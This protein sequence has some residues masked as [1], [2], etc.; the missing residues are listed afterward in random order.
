MAMLK[1]CLF[2]LGNVLLNF[3]HDK[4]I[5]Q[6][7]E[8]AGRAEADVRREFLDTGKH[9]EY[10]RGE[11]STA[12]FHQWFE[13]FARR[14]ID[15]DA[16]CVAVADIFE[17]NVEMPPL[18]DALKSR[19]LRLV[20]MSNTNAAHY[21]FV[22]ERFDV[23]DRFDHLVLSFEVGAMKPDEPIYRA[24]LRNI[25][26][27]PGECFYTDDI[28]AYVARGRDFGLHAEV[29][30]SAQELREHLSRHGVLI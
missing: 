27:A 6:M 26:C 24:A 8:L 15:R 20:L 11:I 16:L 21:E 30:T 12:A 22:R 14:S 29:F 2:D 18:L 1:T 5:R 25:D 9:L 13:A 28:P 17:L 23:L 19:G 3:S 10:E 4:M 7:A